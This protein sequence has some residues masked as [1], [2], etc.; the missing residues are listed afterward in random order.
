MAK[1]AQI[2]SISWQRNNQ[3]INT[4]SNKNQPPSLDYLYPIRYYKGVNTLK[5]SEEF[6][7]WLMKLKDLK[8]KA[9]MLARIKS[10][11]LGNF[12][13]CK[14]LGQNIFEMK[15][16]TGPGY[17]IYYACIDTKVY[18]LLAGGDK[19]TQARDIHRAKQI[20]QRLKED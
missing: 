1:G 18:L 7:T 6:N 20:F 14:A 9:R 17:R 11:E 2:F 8:G 3:A 4:K 15:V 13:N 16:D 5:A 19:S 12:G 10:A